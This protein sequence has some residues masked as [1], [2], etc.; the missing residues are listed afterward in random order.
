MAAQRQPDKGTVDVE[1]YYI[2]SLGSMV[3]AIIDL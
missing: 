1:I 3:S 2:T